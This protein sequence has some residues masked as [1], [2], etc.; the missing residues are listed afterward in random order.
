MEA[1]SPQV[2]QERSVD[3][4]VLVVLLGDSQ[5]QHPP[6]R[7]DPVHLGG[8]PGRSP[9][10]PQPGPEDPPQDRPRRCPVDIG[11]PNLL[12]GLIGD[13]HNRH[14]HEPAEGPRGLDEPRAER[15]HRA[16]HLL[17]VHPP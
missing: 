5:I 7:L 11:L 6:R 17:R 14:V 4:E 10:D 2:L 1:I 9:G 12:P 13:A 15:A 3:R 16:G 8:H